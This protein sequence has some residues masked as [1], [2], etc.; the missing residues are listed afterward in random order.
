MEDNP[1]KRLFELRAEIAKA[2]S[3]PIRL[4]M[5]DILNNEGDKCVC[6]LTE[7][8]DLSQP[9]ISKHLKILKNSGIVSSKKKGVKTYYS[10]STPCVINF[11][12]CMDE[13]LKEDLTRND[14]ISY[15]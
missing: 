5:V 3:H 15:L 9:S 11:F 1:Q 8:L 10:L 7:V 13:V 2:L 4:K 6:E 14:L 12:K